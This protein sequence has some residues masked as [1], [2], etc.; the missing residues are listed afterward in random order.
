MKKVLKF[1]SV[2]NVLIMSICVVSRHH[3]CHAAENIAMGQGTPESVMNAWL[4]SQA[5][6]DNIL[7]SSYTC[8]GIAHYM[9]NDID[10]WVQYYSDKSVMNYK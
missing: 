4:N 1:L 3:Y 6:R 10:Y 8:V 5:H 2:Q 9:Q 7:S